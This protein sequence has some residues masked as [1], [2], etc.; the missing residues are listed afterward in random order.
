LHGF[1]QPAAWLPG[2]EAAGHH[3]D[4]GPPYTQEYQE[5]QG[6]WD[7]DISPIMPHSS[8]KCSSLVLQNGLSRGLRL[9]SNHTLPTHRSSGVSTWKVRSMTVVHCR[10]RMIKVLGLGRSVFISWHSK[11]VGE[12]SICFSVKLP[13][14]VLTRQTSTLSQEGESHPHFKSVFAR[15]GGEHL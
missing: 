4:P 10:Q 15:C 2:P 13:L 12:A 7:A 5:H 3:S 1:H 9:S 14:V 11:E 8:H 6:T